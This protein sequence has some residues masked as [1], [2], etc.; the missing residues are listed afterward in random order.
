M[1]T[2][3]PSKLTLKINSVL[4]LVEFLILI[5]IV[6]RLLYKQYTSGFLKYETFYG[7]ILMLG[8]SACIAFNIGLHIGGLAMLHDIEKEKEMEKK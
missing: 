1:K 4:F 7:S 5:P 2:K 8:I 6:P 3:I